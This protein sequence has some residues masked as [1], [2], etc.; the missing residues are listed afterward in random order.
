M[1]EGTAEETRIIDA[2]PRAVFEVITDF[3]AYP[4]IFPEFREVEVLEDEG[5]EAVVRFRAHFGIDLDYTLRIKR[6]FP[7]VSWTLVEG[8]LK[9]SQGSW[10]L[11]AEGEGTTRVTYRLAAA[12]GF[13]VPRFVSDRLVAASLPP[14]LDKL[15]AEVARRLRKR[16]EDHEASSAS[17]S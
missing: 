5:E 15:A 7:A 11:V 17:S 9:D 14:T 3:E 16:G 2:P 1:S 13:Y 10:S 4:R 12:V 6:S 8:D